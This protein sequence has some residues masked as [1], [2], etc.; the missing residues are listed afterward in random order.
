MM[1]EP[2]HGTQPPTRPL[3]RLDSWEGIA[4]YLKRDV[5]T[6][7]R[8]EKREGMPVHRHLHDKVGSVYAFRSELDTWS[9]SRRRRLEE[10]EE[11]RLEPSGEAAP[12]HGS[13]ATP[14]ARAGLVLGGAIVL[15]LLAV[16]VVMSRSH[17]TRSKIKSLAVL[18]L[19]NLSGDPTQEYLADGMT[20]ALIG[21]LSGIGDLRVI[22]R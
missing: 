21:R 13:R 22:S 17:A 12:R 19:K 18:P 9:Q 11:P 2:S 8:W 14:R 16:T 15:A 1:S 6:V 7:Q 10:K 4:V 20:E 3:D 5:T